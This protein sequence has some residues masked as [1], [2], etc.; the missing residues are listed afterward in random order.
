[1]TKEEFE[2][3]EKAFLAAMQG[4]SAGVGYDTPAYVTRRSS[5]LADAALAVWR[6]KRK[7]VERSHEAAVTIIAGNPGER[8]AA[9]FA[10][11]CTCWRCMGMASDPY[12]DEVKT[13]DE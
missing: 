9:P 8:I 4:I 5:E 13:N 2:F 3:W 11:R 1:M 7:E 12:A 6:E 10:P